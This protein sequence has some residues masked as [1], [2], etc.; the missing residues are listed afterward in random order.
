[1]QPSKILVV[2]E[3]PIVCLG[4]K[5]ALEDYIDA[6]LAEEATCIQ[7]ALWTVEN[8]RPD[9]VIMED[10]MPYLNGGETRLLI[11]CIETTFH[12]KQIDPAIEV[13][14]FTAT[15]P[16]KKLLGPLK[17]V[18]ISAFVLK[19]DPISELR[20]AIDIASRGGTY[21][22]R[23]VRSYM[24]H[25][26]ERP[27]QVRED[28]KVDVSRDLGKRLSI[29]KSAELLGVDPETLRVHKHSAIMRRHHHP[30]A[31]RRAKD[32][33]HGE[34]RRRERRTQQRDGIVALRAIARRRSGGDRRKKE[35][36]LGERRAACS[37]A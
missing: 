3:Q 15:H 13:I 12:I 7:D 2:D 16:Y 37:D 35:R 1:M 5:S 34:R 14:I 30:L 6:K 22:S 11:S 8:T 17:R 28:K 27:L 31:E 19:Q 26:I 32:R 20:T 23:Q 25:L 18:G 9:L 24:N 33:R 4:I 29:D 10:L 21:F 36:R